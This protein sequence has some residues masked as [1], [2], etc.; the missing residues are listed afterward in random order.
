MPLEGTTGE[1]DALSFCGTERGARNN[2]PTRGRY[3]R[4]AR[5]ANL[6]IVRQEGDRG[7]ARDLAGREWDLEDPTGNRLRVATPRR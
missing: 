5:L 2:D 6:G 7:I 3:R 1:V 4:R